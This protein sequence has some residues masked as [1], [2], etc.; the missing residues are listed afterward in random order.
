MR[1]PEIS[2]FFGMLLLSCW[3]LILV[4]CWYC[5]KRVFGK[6]GYTDSGLQAILVMIPIVNLFVLYKFVFKEW[7]IQEKLKQLTQSDW[8]R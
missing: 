3:I 8:Q 1:S 4:F 7:P 5:Y 6:A 2:I